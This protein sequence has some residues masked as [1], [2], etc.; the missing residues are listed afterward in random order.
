M[1]QLFHTDV[2]KVDQEA[3]YVAVV[4]HMCC[5]RMFPMFYLFFFQTYVASAFIWMFAYVS[6]ICCNMLQVLGDSCYCL[7]T[8]VVDLYVARRLMNRRG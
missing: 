5:K 1:F 2:A 8:Q 4:V 7:I 3:A 6:H